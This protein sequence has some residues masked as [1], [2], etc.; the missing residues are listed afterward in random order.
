MA[1]KLSYEL[2]DA[3]LSGDKDRVRSIKAE[4][5]ASIPKSRPKG[6]HIEEKSDLADIDTSVIYIDKILK[7]ELG[8]DWCENE[9][10]T[11]WKL[12]F[13][14]SGIVLDDQ[15]RDKISAIKAVRNSVAPFEQWYSFNQVCTAFGGQGADFLVMTMPT[16]G[17]VLYTMAAMQAIGGR[18]FSEEVLKYVCCKLV[19]EGIYVPPPTISDLIKIPMKWYTEK[20]TQQVWSDVYS[21]YNQ[22]IGADLDSIIPKDDIV[23]IQAYRLVLTERAAKAYLEER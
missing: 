23:D 13:T 15:V 8:E 12:L 22:W 3:I 1:K 9:L 7:R 17:Q 19:S 20:E 5:E 18:E 11:I 6:W 16:P 4:I 2:Y 10:E 14:D 21:R